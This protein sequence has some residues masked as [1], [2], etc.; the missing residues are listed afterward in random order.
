M[1]I[2]NN[3]L[4]QLMMHCPHVKEVDVLEDSETDFNWKYFSTML[5]NS[6]VWNL[7]SLPNNYMTIDTEYYDNVSII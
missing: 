2:R 1:D 3:P 4:F 6:G 7:Q 5:V